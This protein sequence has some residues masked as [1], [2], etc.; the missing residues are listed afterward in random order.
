MLRWALFMAVV[1]A[2]AGLL[3]VAGFSY[4]D[5]AVTVARSAL[6]ADA[7]PAVIEPARERA[8]AAGWNEVVVDADGRG[9]FLLEAA[10][11]GTPVLFL[12]DTGASA[13]VLSPDD[14]RRVG[15]H[16]QRLTYSQRFQ[17][18]GGVVRAAPVTL[19]EV[20]VGQ[21]ALYD[22]PAS[23]NE[24]PLGISLLGMGFLSRLSGYE[25]RDGRLVLRW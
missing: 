20:R 22:L 19:R 3:V 2:A 21:F 9:H 17:T 18:A 13:V 4:R 23:V 6:D 24:A 7:E 5:E 11:N 1:Y 25:V 16:P 15:L 8:H 10:V 14:A 12:V